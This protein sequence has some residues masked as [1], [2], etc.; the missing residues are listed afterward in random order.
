M[1]GT[2]ERE[3][4]AVSHGVKL[5]DLVSLLQRSYEGRP[6]VVIFCPTRERFFIA[7]KGVQVGPFG[8]NWDGRQLHPD[9]TPSV[10]DGRPS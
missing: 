10:G 5:G 4:Y 6:C 3:P 2:K 8:L 7:Q 9:I 1:E